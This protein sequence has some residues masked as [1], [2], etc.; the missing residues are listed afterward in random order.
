MSKL[1]VKRI[2]QFGLLAFL[3][4]NET[5]GFYLCWL[6]FLPKRDASFTSKS[7]QNF[8]ER[9]ASIN[10]LILFPGMILPVV[11]LLGLF[12]IESISTFSIKT[13]LMNIIEEIYLVLLVATISN[14]VRIMSEE[15][16]YSGHQFYQKAITDF[17][18]IINRDPESIKSIKAYYLRGIAKLGLDD[19]EE[20]FDDFR[21]GQLLEVAANKLIMHHDSESSNLIAKSVKMEYEQMINP[22]LKQSFF[23]H[24]DQVTTITDIT[25]CKP[26]F[27]ENS[28]VVG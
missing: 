11:I 21:K 18:E 2:F 12:I 15:M 13:G 19:R 27:F 26:Y 4:G 5:L 24:T 1:F 9:L 20:G 17:T 10:R 28:L 14:Y 16:A 7:Y 8:W 23:Y 25:Q 3:R 22:W 6:M